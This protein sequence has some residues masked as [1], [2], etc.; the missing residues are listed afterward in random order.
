[1]LWD[2]WWL[3][4]FLVDPVAPIGP[5][6]MALSLRCSAIFNV[7]FLQ[8]VEISEIW[9][10]LRKTVEETQRLTPADVT[11]WSSKENK[12]YSSHFE[13]AVSVYARWADQRCTLSQISVIRILFFIHNHLQS[14]KK[15]KQQVKQQWSSKIPCWCHKTEWKDNK[16]VK[17]ATTEVRSKTSQNAQQPEGHTCVQRVNSPSTVSVTYI[18]QPMNHSVCQ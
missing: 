13:L 3:E 9:L 16:S 11:W 4:G 8:F 12:V 10:V 5:E 1:M 2:E 6:N 18:T 7:D 15:R 14:L 17:Q